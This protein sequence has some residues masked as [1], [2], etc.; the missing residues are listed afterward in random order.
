MLSLEELVQ[1]LINDG[2]GDI[3][4][5]E[6]ILSTLKKGQTLY[7]SDQE[8]LEKLLAETRK[9]N[10]PIQSNE[11]KVAESYSESTLNE[12]ESKDTIVQPTEIELLRKEIHKLQDK[13]HVIEEH[14]K[15]QKSGSW[16]RAF[17]RGIAG[18]FL[19]LFGLGM[20]F[21]LYYHFSNLDNSMRGMHYGGDPWAVIIG[22]FVIIP[23][24][25]L[26]IGGS[27]IYYGIRIISKT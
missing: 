21:I 6:H 11:P 20:V 18:I 7:T 8:Y 25:L 22:A 27:S 5:L 14:L 26:G 4:R 23:A 1:E 17:G 10:D 2:K 19:F 15:K 9:S 24:I 13:N 16:A 3:G 12:N